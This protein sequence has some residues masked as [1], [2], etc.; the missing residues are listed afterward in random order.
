MRSVR[1]EWRDV[2][3]YEGRY[4][5]SSMGRVSS[6]TYRGSLRAEPIILKPAPR[7]RSSAHLGVSLLSSKGRVTRQVAH[8]VAEAFIGPRPE[9]MGCLHRNGVSTDNR[10]GNLYYGTQADNVSDARRH[11]TLS[12]GEANGRA[13]LDAD[14][15]IQIRRAVALGSP[16]KEQAALYGVSAGAIRRIV[17]GD[18]WG[19]I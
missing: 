10:K 8:L 3:G 1:E 5:V 17:T 15:V 9:G 19:H 18:R 7:S 11:G 12:S 14:R 4:L 16:P 2:V 6:L 13:V